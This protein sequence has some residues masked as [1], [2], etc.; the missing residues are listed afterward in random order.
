[1]GVS[2]RK[3]A[4]AGTAGLDAGA[5][6]SGRTTTLWRESRWL[7]ACEVAAVALIF[8]ADWRHLIPFSK[9]PFLLV[10]GWI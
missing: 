5:A 10:L 7:A 8:I 6:A 1:M 2:N 4:P 9:T 3:D